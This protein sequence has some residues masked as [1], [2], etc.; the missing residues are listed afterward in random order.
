[1]TVARPVGTLDREQPQDDDRLAQRL[2]Q[3]RDDRL[4]R[5]PPGDLD[6]GPAKHLPLV[7]GGGVRGR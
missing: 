1:M 7:G 6:L 2:L 5:R 4:D 3:V